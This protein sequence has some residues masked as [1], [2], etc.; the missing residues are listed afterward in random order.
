MRRL[1]EAGSVPV[2]TDDGRSYHL[3]P[4]PGAPVDGRPAG[5]RRGVS[6]AQPHLRRPAE[7]TCRWC[8]T[9]RC[10]KGRHGF[11]ERR[12][13]GGALVRIDLAFSR[14]SRRPA[15]AIPGDG[16]G[17]PAASMKPTSATRADE[18]IVLVD[19]CPRSRPSTSSSPARGSAAFASAMG[20]RSPR[21]SRTSRSTSRSST[22]N[23]A[24]DRRILTPVSGRLC[25]VPAMSTETNDRALSRGALI[26][27]A[28]GAGL[29]VAFGARALDA[30][31]ADAETTATCVLQPEV[32]EG[33]Y[34]IDQKLTRRDTR[35]S[36]VTARPR[37][38]GNARTCRPIKG[39][40]VG[41]G[42]A[43]ERQT[44]ASTPAPAEGPGGGSGPATS[45]LPR[46]PALECD[47]VD[48]PTVFPAGSRAAPAHP[49]AHRP[50]PRSHHSPFFNEAAPRPYK[51]R[52][53]QPA[54]TTRRT[55][56]IRSTQAG[57]L[58]RSSGRR[59]GRAAC[60]YAGRIGR[61]RRLK[62]SGPPHR[63]GRRAAE[64]ELPA[65][66]ELV[67]VDAA[68]WSRRRA[69]RARSRRLR[70][71]YRETGFSGPVP[72]SDHCRPRES[73]EM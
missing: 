32:T 68:A 24:S 54:S 8:A 59:S 45:T 69:C 17:D 10:A 57:A 21:R 50:G 47:G 30:L 18:G 55:L 33:P 63:E 73:F 13:A 49:E 26:K 70:R 62:D 46:S 56:G 52:R 25:T 28:G 9:T 20:C 66:G 29:A 43:R 31:G 38:H 22:G 14:R 48:L 67:H 65:R 23:A 3:V 34:S 27:A 44:P 40:D 53:T 16:R 11:S 61:R 35:A 2:P 36:P 1:V 64:C 15:Q 5:C 58:G 4:P 42:T 6:P 12:A 41:S 37:R 72:S 60:G 71:G 7:G 19:T 51:Q 39:A